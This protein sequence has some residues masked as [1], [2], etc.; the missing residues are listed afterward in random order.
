MSTHALA[1]DCETI[2]GPDAGKPCVFPF[3]IDNITFNGCT[4]EGSDD[5]DD[6]PRCSTA[7]DDKGNHERGHW[8]YCGDGCPLQ[9]TERGMNN[10]N[11]SQRPRQHGYPV[12]LSNL[13]Y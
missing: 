10:T 13:Y 1:A 4:T 12:I 11:L 9:D 3:K 2:G 7:V 8:G 6:M 5:D